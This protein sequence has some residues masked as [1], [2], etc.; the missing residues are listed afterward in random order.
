MDQKDEKWVLMTELNGE[1]LL[2][3]F[4]FSNHGRVVRMKKGIGMEEKFIPKEIN[5]YQFVSFT[6]RMGTRAT[7]YLHRLIAEFFVAP[8]EDVVTEFVIH[9]DGNKQNNHQNNLRWIT[10]EEM[11]R[12]R[13]ESR[14]KKRKTFAKAPGQLKKPAELQIS[15]MQV[16]E[17][18]ENR[19]KLA[20]FMGVSQ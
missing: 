14:T 15:E 18:A 1:P 7:L 3:H 20:E 6:T 17:L 10:Q 5:G 13:V 8:P 4:K 9:I 19:R 16:L 2:H 11:L 12:R